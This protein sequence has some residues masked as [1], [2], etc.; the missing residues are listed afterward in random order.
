MKSKIEKW[1]TLTDEITSKWVKDYFKI[2]E[3]EVDFWWVGDEVGSIF[4]FGDYWVNFSDVLACY[5]YNINKEQFFKW[6]DY[7]L[8]NEYIKISLANYILDPQ[9]KKEQEEKH[10]EFLK[11]R[12]RTSQKELENA[13]NNFK[14]KL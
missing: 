6:Y 3:E 5:R 14:N 7:C 11:E 10:I 2:S 8:E 9:K 13:I 4:N 12:L 1:K